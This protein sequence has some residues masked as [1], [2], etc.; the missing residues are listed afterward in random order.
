MK[1]SFTIIVMIRWSS[2]VSLIGDYMF[3]HVSLR[4]SSRRWSVV[5]LVL[6]VITLTFYLLVIRV[7]YQPLFH[8]SFSQ[9]LYHISTLLLHTVTL[10]LVNCTSLLL[11]WT[12]RDLFSQW[13]DAIAHMLLQSSSSVVRTHTHAPAL[14]PHQSD[15]TRAHLVF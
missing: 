8:F 12:K 3:Y 2:S 11:K 9:L 13:T 4:L 14:W 6:K 15:H 5:N 1:G 10:K 7:I